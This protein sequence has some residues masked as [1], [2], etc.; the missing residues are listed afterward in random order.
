MYV[1][2]EKKLIEETTFNDLGMKESDVEELLRQNVEMLCDDEDSLLI[3]GQQVAN[4]KKGRSDLI[5]IDNQGNVVLIEIKRD[6]KDI[7]HRKEAFEFQAIRYAASFA[8]LRTVEEFLQNVYAPY[9]EK[10]KFEFK[11]YITLTSTEIAQRE[12]SNFFKGNNLSAEDFNKKQRI[13]LVASEFD[14]QT[15]SAVAWLNSNS[16]DI[17]CY[18]INLNKFNQH[19]ILNMEKIL[20]VDDYNDYLVN[21]VQPKSFIQKKKEA[22]ITR[23]ILPKIDTLIEWG[24]VSEGDV[25][26]S[27][28]SE[29]AEVTLLRDG[30]VKTSSNE[31]LTIQQWLKKL[32]GWSAVET[33]KFTID[34][35]TG[36]TLSKLREEYMQ[37]EK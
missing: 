9:V 13:V 15:L 17:A 16:V 21:I 27:D 18:K 29:K 36:K 22:K 10:H 23:K 4:E 31:I 26:I 25:L 6:K 19:I 8:T 33:Y 1:L 35:K 12:L 14:E 28:T 11:D 37:A 3:V 20:P 7:E 30:N 5:A 34:K 32:T 24:I 2:E